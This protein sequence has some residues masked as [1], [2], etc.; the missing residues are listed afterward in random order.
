MNE[1]EFS[2]ALGADDGAGIGNVLSKTTRPDY[3]A[4][5]PTFSQKK[6]WREAWRDSLQTAGLAAVLRGEVPFELLKLQPRPLIRSMCR[7]E[8][9]NVQSQRRPKVSHQAGFTAES[10]MIRG[11]YSWT[12]WV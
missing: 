6:K 4:E 2:I 5:T 7:V 11:G 9:T 12:S 8:A 1:N 3:P 10:S